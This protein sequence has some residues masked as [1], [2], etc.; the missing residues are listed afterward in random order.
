MDKKSK[1]KFERILI[2]SGIA[3]A[4]FGLLTEAIQYP[5]G[6]L[7]GQET[8]PEDPTPV[9]D[10]W[11]SESVAEE[12]VVYLAGGDSYG[13]SAEQDQPV[14]QV[15]ILKLPTLGK[16]DNV[17]EGDDANTLMLGAGHIPG[18]ALPGQAGNCAIA[19]RRESSLFYH[20]EL[21]GEDASILLADQTQQY[22]YTVFHTAEV[23]P[24]DVSVLEP[25]EGRDSV[26]TLITG[27]PYGSNKKRL[28]V[29][30]ELT[31]TQPR[32]QA[33]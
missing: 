10:Q 5:W 17:L 2:I 16:A 9:S 30:A 24:T 25:V 20:L 32:S 6:A 23:V 1:R 11:A 33:Q 15:G 4:A 26:L 12:D 18:T 22:T 19:G 3:L 27:T 13:A 29:Q 14:L 21:V 31:D 28:I 7:A 8:I